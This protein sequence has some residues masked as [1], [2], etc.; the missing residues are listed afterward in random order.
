MSELHR[1]K[2][3]YF[4]VEEEPLLPGRKTHE[5]DV[6]N[7]SSQRSLGR[8]AWYGGWRQFCFFPCADT[9]WSDGCLVDILRVVRQLKRMRT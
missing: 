8:I 1:W 5:Y 2:T 4:T 6:V 3:R 7:N 9:V